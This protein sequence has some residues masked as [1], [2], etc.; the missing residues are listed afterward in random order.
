MASVNKKK[1]G[2]IKASELISVKAPQAL[3]DIGYLHFTYNTKTN[4]ADV[5]RY[6]G[7][8]DEFSLWSVLQW[9]V[10]DAEKDALESRMTDK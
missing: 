2:M 1:A 9:M 3:R 8:V 4:R 6:D 5:T 10:L 7:R